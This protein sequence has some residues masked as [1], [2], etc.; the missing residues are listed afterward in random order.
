MASQMKMMSQKKV[1][2]DLS[3]KTCNYCKENGHQIH[4][5]G[6]N[7][8]LVKGDDGEKVLACPLLI[9]KEKR[10]GVNKPV[11]ATASRDE[12]PPLS[13]S[14]AVTGTVGSTGSSWSRVVAAN[15]S[16]EE[17][18]ASE[19]SARE[20][21]AFSHA[22]A[23]KK[24]DRYLEI[25]AEKEQKRLDWEERYSKRMQDKHGEMWYQVV[26]NTEDDNAFA[27]S[28]RSKKVEEERA[29]EDDYFYAQREFDMKLEEEER[30]EA[31]R[32]LMTR[33]ERWEEEDQHM[34]D[35]YDEIWREMVNRES[36]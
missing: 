13:L 19:K 31:R 10:R 28:I 33:E 1:S 26:K 14:C 36:V 12:F 5:V 34:D 35:I 25:K 24:K 4:A 6:P 2:F 21:E 18:N 20:V 27:A 22:L 30:E 17:M 29:R 8:A 3:V 7:G 15:L 9:A 11:S 16:P 32:S 23:K